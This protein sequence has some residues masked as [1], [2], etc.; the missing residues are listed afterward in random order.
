MKTL[1][2]EDLDTSQRGGRQCGLERE[3][4][5]PRDFGRSQIRHHFVIN[6]FKAYD[7]TLRMVGAIKMKVS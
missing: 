1:R 7:F 2:R 3:V 6:H 4:Q 5:E